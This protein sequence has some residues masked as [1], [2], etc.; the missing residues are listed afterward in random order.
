MEKPAHRAGRA[1]SGKTKTDG[2]T[3]TERMI[4]LLRAHL[5]T[6]DPEEHRH[7]QNAAL[8]HNVD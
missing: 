5:A 4:N 8:C 2:A 6:P 1:R 7:D 3:K